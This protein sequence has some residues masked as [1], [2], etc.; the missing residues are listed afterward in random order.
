MKIAW[1]TAAAT[2]FTLYMTLLNAG[3]AFGPVLTRLGLGYAESYL[4]CAALAVL[5]L[6]VLPLLDPESVVRRRRLDQAAPRDAARGE[7]LVVD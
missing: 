6:A 7:P 4:L 1:T 3:N 2:Q 5:P